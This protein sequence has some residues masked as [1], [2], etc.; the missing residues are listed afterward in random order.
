M[1]R[2]IF[3]LSLL[4]VAAGC[5]TTPA[6]N[7]STKANIIQAPQPGPGESAVFGKI[8]LINFVNQIAMPEEDQNGVLYLRKEGSKTLYKI[9]CSPY[10]SFGVYL[11]GGEYR[12]AEVKVGHYTFDPDLALSVPAEQRAAYTGTVVF[13]GTPTGIIPGNKGIFG[14]KLDTKFVFS[15]KDEQKD[16]ESEVKRDAPDAAVKFY[17]SLF[18]P[19]GGI[20][21][22]HYPNKISNPDEVGKDLRAR[23]DAVEEWVGG[24]VI[25]LPYVI[26]PG[27]IFTLPY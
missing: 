23:S 22:G 24:V 13:D 15:V 8:E 10:G 3:S 5:A 25:A 26:N 11:P 17:K 21:A 16:L 4:L 20:A 18:T 6:K 2:L 9:N 1:K 7:V 19:A 12:L 27:L 14:S